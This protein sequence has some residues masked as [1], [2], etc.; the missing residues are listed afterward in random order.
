MTNYIAEKNIQQ[1]ATVTLTGGLTKI[2]PKCTTM[3][4]LFYRSTIGTD[5]HGLAYMTYGW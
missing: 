2:R 1:I 5:G 4:P 3:D